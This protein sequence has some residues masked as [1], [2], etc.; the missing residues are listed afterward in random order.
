MDDTLIPVEHFALNVPILQADGGGVD[1]LRRLEGVVENY[2][3]LCA[4]TS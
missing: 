1:A 2:F 3:T 4:I